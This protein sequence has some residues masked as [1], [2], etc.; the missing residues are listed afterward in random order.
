[1]KTRRP[2]NHYEL[3]VIAIVVVKIVMGD[4]GN[5]T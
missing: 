5:I 2:E 3:K 1:M 4:F